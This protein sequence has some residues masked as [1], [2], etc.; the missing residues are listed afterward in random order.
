LTK[1]ICSLWYRPIEILLGEEVYHKEVD[2]WSLGALIIEIFCKKAPFRGHCEIEQ[3]F[4]IFKVKGTPINKSDEG[5]LMRSSKHA[6]IT[7]FK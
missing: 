7:F 6:Q 1:E 3:I 2:I 4:E 5:K